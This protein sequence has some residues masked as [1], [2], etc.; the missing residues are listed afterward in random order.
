MKYNFVRALLFAVILSFS[1]YSYAGTLIAGAN[2]E[3][4]EG[5]FN[6]EAFD[7]GWGLHL[8]YEFREWKKWKFGTLFEFMDGWYKKE[9]LDAVGEMAYDSKSL[10]AT[11]RPVGWPLL[12]KAGI[13]DA[14]YT[15]LQQESPQQFRDVSKTGYAYG[16]SLVLG[17]EKFRLDIIDYKRIKIGNDNFTSYGISLGI[18]F[19]GHGSFSSN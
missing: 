7:G 10:Y 19:G 16:V 9:D 11:A 13:V 4:V 6:D 5:S 14:N 2:L 15:V 17:N 1:S 3:F 18:I 12:F 8:G